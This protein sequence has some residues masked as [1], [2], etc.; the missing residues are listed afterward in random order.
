MLL[1][2]FGNVKIGSVWKHKGGNLYIVIA[3]SNVAG[4]TTKEKYPPSFVYA[5]MANHT[6]ALVLE[7][8]SLIPE[9]GPQLVKF[10]TARADDWHRRMT[11]VKVKD[12]LFATLVV[13]R[14]A[15]LV[16]ILKGERL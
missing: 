13:G 14:M 7:D 16:R 8:T 6:A 15:G 5:N 10:W 9:H 3:I 2:E 4:S 12:P 11:E 1:Q